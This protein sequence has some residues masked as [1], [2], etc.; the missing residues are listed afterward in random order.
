MKRTRISH[1]SALSK[2]E[3][4]RKRN[5]RGFSMAE[6]LIVVAII[7]VLVAIAIPVFTGQ[8]EKNRDSITATNLRAAY[9]EANATLL[10][11][12]QKP[13]DGATVTVDGVDYRST[14][15]S[16]SGETLPFALGN[17]LP[18][19]AGIYSLEFRF[20][21]DTATVMTWSG[22]A[23]GSGSA[24]IP[25]PTGTPSPSTDTKR[26]VENIS[27]SKNPKTTY[28][29]GESFVPTGMEL[30]VTYDSGDPD[31][32]SSGYSC[33]NV[34][35][36][37]VEGTY[38]VTVNYEGH[39]ALL[40]I[41]V[42]KRTVTRI[43]ITQ[44]PSNTVYTEGDTFDPKDMKV[45][46]YYNYSDDDYKDEVPY[47]YRPTGP[48]T[49]DIESITVSYEGQMAEQEITVN[50]LTLLSIA[51]SASQTE[52]DAEEFDL[53]ALLDDLVV[54]AYYEGGKSERIETGYTH[55][56]VDDKVPS[57]AGQ[58]TLMVRYT[59]DDDNKAE[60]PLVITITKKLKKIEVTED[61]VL[62]Y[63]VGQEFN[64]ADIKVEATYTDGSHAPVNTEAYSCEPKGPYTTDQIGEVTVTVSY[65]EGEGDN[66]ITET[67][68]VN[69]TVSDRVLQSIAITSEN[70]N[71]EYTQGK[72][73]STE[74]LV[75]TATYDN[76]TTADVTASC[77]FDPA[78]PYMNVGEQTVTVSYTEGEKTETTTLKITVSERVLQSI[79]I[80]SDHHKTEYTQG[81]SL[82]TE[83]LVVTATYDNGTTAVVTGSCT[84]SPTGPYMEVEDIDIQVSYTE[85]KVTAEVPLT[86][87][88]SKRTLQSI[89][90]TSVHHK[91]EYIQ[92]ESFSTE[93][94]V[95]TATYDNGTTA[96]VTASCQ[97]D[98]AGPYGDVGEKT[99]TVSYTEGE[100]TAE[101]PLKI[102]VKEL[103]LESVTIGSDASPK[104]I[105][106]YNEEF[107]RTD[108]SVIAHYNSGDD[109][110][111]SATCIISNE[112]PY[113]TTGVQE[114]TVTYDGMEANR[115][116]TITVGTLDEITLS[117]SYQ[118]YYPYDKDDSPNG[119]RFSTANLYVTAHYKEDAVPSRPVTNFYTSPYTDGSYLKTPYNYDDSDTKTITVTYIEGESVTATYDITIEETSCFAA[120]TLIT[121]ADGTQKPV[122]ELTFDDELLVWDF[123]TGTYGVRPA[124]LLINHGEDIYAVT[125]LRFSDGTL[126]RVIG[127]HGVFDYD[128]NR[129]VYLSTENAADFIGH[130]FVKCAPEGEY[131]LVTLDSVEITE[132]Q[133]EAWSV[134]SSGD[135]NV[136]ASDLLTLSPP[137]EVF[138]LIPMGETL[139]YDMDLFRQLVAE[140]GT[141][142][143]EVYAQFATREQYEALNGAYM[144]IP[145]EMGLLSFEELWT[146]FESILSFM[147]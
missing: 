94:L 81:E 48:L 119:A 127:D 113:I 24:P 141:Y 26:T 30:T 125:E 138:D 100:V 74:G 40:E 70:H 46:A 62:V 18:S 19:G 1:L 3:L 75:V 58:Y 52:F 142:D 133:T 139:R 45:R 57:I 126:L 108:L 120:G 103:V 44:E 42:N 147:N 63:S 36:Y 118:T 92:S 102:T 122:E 89:A 106:Y 14:D 128:L 72:S 29:E 11:R 111:V 61:P 77:Q 83:G 5:R 64:K 69:I 47:S 99:V 144:K 78:G 93:G 107:D 76:G 137:K 121:L 67:D 50:K 79:A 136:F 54:T 17:G 131:D 130:R 9:D 91:T 37:R 96:D 49:G 116:I 59:K 25:S 129:F 31:V 65:T 43:E 86:I 8:L 60:A 134:V 110:D 20:N 27:I 84:F 66:A 90:I 2:A 114:L 124:T 51:V 104:L 71:T 112:G 109:V 13:S 28:N 23:S 85:G 95:V 38:T 15:N 123:N 88:V 32:I 143:Y 105:Y 101:V 55:D 6:V 35:P 98:P 135:F 7:A 33:T 73:F 117:G 53:P 12:G 34:G 16:L 21:K 41:T 4:S 97:F 82:S 87:T 39:S 115:K 132:E 10:S 68:T 146:L 140:Y 145:V 22:E 80:T 56:W